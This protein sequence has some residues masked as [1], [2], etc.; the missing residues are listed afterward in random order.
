MKSSAHEVRLALSLVLLALLPLAAGCGGG[1]AEGHEN[2]DGS[3][4]ETVVRTVEA[5]RARR[6][7]LPLRER[8]TGTVRATGQVAIYPQ[9][10][11]PIV[12]VLAE[13]GD[14]VERGDPLVRIR[15]RISQS[16]LEQARANL[17]VAQAELQQAAANLQEMEAR[18]QRTL[19]LAGDSLVSAEAVETQ[20]AQLE[21]AR[22]ARAQARAQVR[23]AEATIAERREALEQT[24]VRAPISGRVG[25]RNAEVGMQV[26]GQT[27]LFTIGSLDHM[28][29]EVPVTQ[30]MLGRLREGEPVEIHAESLPD[31]VI[32]AQISRI[33][34]FLEEGSFS[35]EAEIDVS[36]EGG[37][38]LPGMFVTVDVYYGESEQ[39]TLVPKSALYEN[40]V[41]GQPGVFVAPS[42]GLEIQPLPA[43]GP[44]G[45]GP[46]TPP[47]PLRFRTVE[48][49]AEGQQI[50]GLEGVESGDWVVVVGQHLLSGAEGE[51]PVTARIRPVTWERIV[52]LQQLQREDLLR[53]FM[54]KQQRLA[55]QRADSIAAAGGSGSDSTW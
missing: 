41:T 12:E 13:D 5:V 39:A 35:A 27:A 50:V 11:G 29:I 1:E 3:G 30:E 17:E 40:P 45:T 14:Q 31:T 36:N 24:V 51:G 26:D 19:L 28:R 33:S 55:R 25:Q 8:M 53:Q 34:P 42:L 7:G 22:A 52:G 43:S 37:T 47:T 49:V 23:Q 38:L 10:S 2:A 6:G 18:F 20:R 32:T 9:V 15:P 46:F 48:V 16:Q 44:D 54:E 4:A 21:A